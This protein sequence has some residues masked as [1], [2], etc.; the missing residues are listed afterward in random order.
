MPTLA[1]ST[2]SSLIAASALLTFTACGSANRD[3]QNNMPWGGVQLDGDDDHGHGGDD[4]GG[5]DTSDALDDDGSPL[6]GDDGASDDGG[7]DDG[8]PD[9]G[10]PDDGG[11]DDG[12]PEEPAGSPYVGEWDIGNCQ[13]QVTP[14]GTG[15]GQVVPDFLLT[16]QF[17][18]QVRLYDFCHKA[19]YLVEG[20]FW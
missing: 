17:G 20:A 1:S 3:D 16:D 14:S 8:L 6:P 19:V 15:V 11:S 13:D 18:D 7:G 12:E 9:D 2:P 4:G 5:S 10:L